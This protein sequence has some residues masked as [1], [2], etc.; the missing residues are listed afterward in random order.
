MKIRSISA[1]AFLGIS[2]ICSGQ[3]DK[4]WDKWNW[5]TGEWQ[6]EGSGIPGEG[7]G[8]FSFSFDLEKKVLVRRSHSEYPGENIKT[9]TLHDDLMIVYLDPKGNPGKAI[10]FDNEGH[11]INYNITYPDSSIVLTSEVI[12]EAPVFRLIYTPLENK[13]VNTRFEMSGDGVS[14]TT[15]VEGRSKKVIH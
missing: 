2:M 8:I 5:L 12:P 14:Y 7:H 10:Y 9:R 15:Y 4:T 6:G 3:Q 11:T 1:I 13:G